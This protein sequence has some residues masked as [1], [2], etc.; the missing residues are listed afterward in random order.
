MYTGLSEPYSLSR[1]E[2]RCL[3]RGCPGDI[4]CCTASGSPGCV[5]NMA[6]IFSLYEW[7]FSDNPGTNNSFSPFKNVSIFGGNAR[8][9]WS[10]P[11]WLLGNSMGEAGRGASGVLFVPLII[12]TIAR[13]NLTGNLWIIIS[14]LVGSMQLRTYG[15]SAFFNA[16]LTCH[17][18]IN[19]IVES[20]GILGAGLICS[21]VSTFTSRFTCLLI[22][23]SLFASPCR[24]FSCCLFLTRPGLERAIESQGACCI[25]QAGRAWSG[26]FSFFTR[27]WCLRR[28]R[29]RF[30]PVVTVGSPWAPEN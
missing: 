4:V 8:H 14:T 26:S 18:N 28:R 27:G 16:G 9:Q 20:F 6:H 3:S 1:Y 2:V 30:H 17:L 21:G 15:F 12:R 22:K 11:C 23:N 7:I 13:N 5:D 25:A 24:H 29:G 19:R 10:L